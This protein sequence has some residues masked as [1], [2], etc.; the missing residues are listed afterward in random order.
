MLHREATVEDVPGAY[1]PR[2][3]ITPQAAGVTVV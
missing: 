1:H 2:Q 3:V